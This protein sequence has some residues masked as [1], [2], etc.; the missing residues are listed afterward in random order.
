M[1][2]LSRSE[3]LAQRRQHFHAVLAPTNQRQ[4]ESTNGPLAEK[5]A[6][7]RARKVADMEI[8]HMRKSKH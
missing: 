5:V 2:I 8:G 6:H 4:V 1:I 3:I 7:A